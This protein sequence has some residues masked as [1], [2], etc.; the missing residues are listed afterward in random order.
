MK[1]LTLTLG[2]ETFGIPVELVQEVLEHTRVTRVPRCPEFLLG[3]VNLRGSIVAVMDLRRRLELPERA[4]SVSTRFVVV[5][6]ELDGRHTP[7]AMMADSVDEV[8]EIVEDDIDP[9]PTMDTS[10]VNL[11][12][13]GKLADRMVLLLDVDTL[14]TDDLLSTSFAAY[15]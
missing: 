5:N 14:L 12:G 11:R 2:D 4:V 1:F 13:V 6:L 10:G 15:G 7:V 8:V 9:A 3:I